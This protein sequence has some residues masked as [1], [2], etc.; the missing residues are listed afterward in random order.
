MLGN[1]FSSSSTPADAQTNNN[2][3]YFTIPFYGAPSL[4]LA[5]QLK[6]IVSSVHKDITIAYRSKKVAQFANRRATLCSEIQSGVVYKFTCVINLHTTYRGRTMR[7]LLTRI[8][9]H[10]TSL[11]AVRNHLDMCPACVND[12]ENRF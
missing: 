10:R 2:K 8:R 9:E 1:A 4:R 12:F 6:R 5:Q 11:S 3:S 7:H